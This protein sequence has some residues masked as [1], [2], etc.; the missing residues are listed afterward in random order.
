MILLLKVSLPPLLV[1]LVSLAARWWGPTVGGMLMGLPWLTG[2]VLIFLAL[3]K[4]LVFAVEACTGIELGVVCVAAFVLAYG[5]VSTFARWPVSVVAGA[6]AF[7]AGALAIEG[8]ALSLPAA[9][10]AAAAS[11]G[12]AYLLLP[13]PRAAVAAAAL[14]WWDIPARM[15]STFLLVGAI[16]L[17]ADLLGPRL[18]GIVSTY[19]TMVTVISA[20]THHQWGRDAVRRLL[21]SLT[22]SLLLF[23]AF[24]LL[25]GLSMPVVGLAASYLVAAAMVLTIDAVLLVVERMRRR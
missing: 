21:R 20:F 24:F 13:R 23:V 7:A 15:G 10:G 1:A 22:L 8:I 9:A 3:D 17:S 18:S 5:V 19:P 6:V 2:P 14:P 12:A 16:L 11:L 4:G 25:V